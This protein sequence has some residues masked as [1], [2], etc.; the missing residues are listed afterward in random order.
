MKNGHLGFGLMR[1]PVN[2]GETTD[3]DFNQVCQ[4]FDTFIDNGFHYFDTSFVYHNGASENIVKRAL[5]DRYDR[6]KYTLATKFPT[7]GYQTEDEIEPIFQQQ[8]EKCGVDYF[9]YYL[10]HNVKTILYPHAEETHLFKHAVKWKEEGK[11]KHLG[12]SFH[13][14]AEVLEQILK[15]HPEIEFVQIVVNYLDWDSGFIQAKMCYELLCQYGKDV[16]IMEPVKGGMLASLPK[17]A[18]DLLKAYNQNA[19]PVSYA[20]RYCA[21]LPNVIAVLSGMSTLQQVQDNILYMKD[22]KPLTEEE[23]ELI[24]SVIEVLKSNWKYQSDKWDEIDQVC[25]VDIPISSIIEAYNNCLLQPNPY[26]SAELNY[27]KNFA[28]HHTPASKCIHCGKCNQVSSLDVEN[29][30]KEAANFL[31]EHSF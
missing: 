19:S 12:I 21:E 1:L 13:D 3:I 2:N 10:L 23:H 20:L 15:E 9:D 6:S 25:P 16:I 26:F 24:D 14:S 29:A 4:M 17:E 22:F 18:N 31:L 7:F 28:I 27:Y 5:V 8:L 11:I 30:L